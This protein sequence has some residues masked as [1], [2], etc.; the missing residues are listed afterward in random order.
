M[1]QS[2]CLELLLVALVVFVNMITCICGETSWGA[3]QW[4]SQGIYMFVDALLASKN[5]G[6]WEQS[7][8]VLFHN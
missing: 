2:K 1:S 7:A 4:A 6:G 8:R 3:H 5:G